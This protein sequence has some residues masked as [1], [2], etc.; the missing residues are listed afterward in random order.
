MTVRLKDAAGNDYKHRPGAGPIRMRM[1]LHDP[2]GTLTTDTLT[3]G[4][5]TTSIY[6]RDGNRRLLIAEVAGVVND[7]VAKEVDFTLAAADSAGWEPGWA[8]GDVKGILA[9]SEVRRYEDYEFEIE[10]VYTP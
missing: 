4:T 7:D 6:E 5:F 3:A 8:I 2:P 1:T 10:R 9:T